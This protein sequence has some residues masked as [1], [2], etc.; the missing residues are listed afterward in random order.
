VSVAEEG[1]FS[2]AAEQLGL[3]KSA[4]SRQIAALEDV[5]GAQLLK[6]STRSVKLTDSGY[7]YLERCRALLADLDEADQAVVALQNEPKGL[8]KINAPMSFGVSHAAPAVAEFMVR[9]P[10]LQVALILNDRFVDPYDEGFDVTLRIG[11][12]ED[13]SL[14]ARKLA[15]IEMGLYAS[16]AYLEK[17]GRP[18]GPDDLKSHA[19]LHY[20][21]PSA[22]SAWGLRGA[23]DAVSIRYRLCSNNGDALRVGA[24]AGLGIALIPAFLVRD[25]VRNGRLVALLDGFEPKPIDL[26][27][28]YPPTRFLAAKVRLFIDF[29]AQRF[30]GSR[31]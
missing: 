11:A 10:D 17:H 31:P 9:H 14:A 21:R 19:A 20:G 8:L 16:P 26:Y 22:K 3:S 1:G 6:R 13:S 24:L 7:A 25:D 28:I 18:R 30:A 23:R 4:A 15:Q 29:L 2:A 5:L 12:L 27:A